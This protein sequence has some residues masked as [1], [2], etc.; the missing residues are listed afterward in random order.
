M[1]ALAE[2]TAERQM[3]ARLLVHF[4]RQV[5]PTPPDA[6][7]RQRADPTN[8]KIQIYRMDV[9]PTFVALYSHLPSD[10]LII[11]LDAYSFYGQHISFGLGTASSYAKFSSLVTASSASR[12]ARI[13]FGL[14][15]ILPMALT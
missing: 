2:T 4:E 13:G 15:R 10:N 1:L 11:D 12:T 5:I 3:F 7:W 6:L 9:P 14:R 8:Q